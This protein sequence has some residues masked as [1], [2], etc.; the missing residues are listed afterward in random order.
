MELVCAG[1]QE[2]IA[3]HVT[4]ASNR[5]MV[6]NA[7]DLETIAGEHVRKTNE[8]SVLG[9]GAVVWCAVQRQSEVG[10]EC[11]QVRGNKTQTCVQ[12]NRSCIATCCCGA[13]EVRQ[14]AEF[15]RRIQCCG[16]VA[17]RESQIVCANAKIAWITPCEGVGVHAAKDGTRSWIVE[18]CACIA[19]DICCLCGSSKQGRD[20]QRDCDIFHMSIICLGCGKKFGQFYCLKIHTKERIKTTLLIFFGGLFVTAAHSKEAQNTGQ[21]FIIKGRF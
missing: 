7:V 6:G 1:S 11:W 18:S 4:E 9:W 10:S 16:E 2:T 8:V 12:I 20:D 21:P 17:A 5:N 19:G 13:I 15:E 14:C 3:N